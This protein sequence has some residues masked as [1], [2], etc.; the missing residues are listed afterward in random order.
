[1]RTI[2][3]VTLLSLSAALLCSCSSISVVDTWRNPSL[4]PARLHKI[5]VVS[6]TR[7]DS[8]RAVYEDV[9]ASELAKHGVEAVASHT[10]MPG[11]QKAETAL[12]DQAVKK[13]AADSVLT[14]QTIKVERQISVQPG[15]VNNYPGYWSPEAFPSW[16]L[17]GYYGSMA[18]YGPAYISSYDVAT[19][20]VNFFGTSTGKLLWAATVSSSEPENVVSVAK[21]LAEMVTRSLSKDGFI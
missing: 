17:Y 21:D 10:I 12:L 1:M 8:N 13:A 20:Q 4:Q 3:R 19:I 2:L 5:L 9:L 15:Y 14:V 6:I 7:K 11:D 18:S 16:D